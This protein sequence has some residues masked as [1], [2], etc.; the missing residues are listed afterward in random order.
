MKVSQGKPGDGLGFCWDLC[1]LLRGLKATANCSVGQNYQMHTVESKLLL[2]CLHLCTF[3]P[4]SYPQYLL[5]SAKLCSTKVTPTSIL[6][7][8]GVLQDPDIQPLLSPG[9]APDASLYS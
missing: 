4:A 1:A 2:Q 8:F 7:D 6:C 3:M 5:S 9:W